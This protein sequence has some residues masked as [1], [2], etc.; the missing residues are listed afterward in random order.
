MVLLECACVRTCVRISVGMVVH[1][2][3]GVCVRVRAR[4]YLIAYECTFAFRSVGVCV[5]TQQVR[6]CVRMCPRFFF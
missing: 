1:T 2:G 4:A 5:H 3:P 6:T